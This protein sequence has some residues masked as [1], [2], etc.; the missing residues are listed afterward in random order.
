MAEPVRVALAAHSF[1][2]F[3]P[4]S[5]LENKIIV[6]VKIHDDGHFLPRRGV[7]DGDLGRPVVAVRFLGPGVP[8]VPHNLLSTATRTLILD[9]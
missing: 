9:P 2:T 7:R 3:L 6:T 1:N 5:I 4:I 8:Q